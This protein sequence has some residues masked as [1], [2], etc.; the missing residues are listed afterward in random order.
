MDCSIKECRKEL[1]GVSV[2]LRDAET[3]GEA[4]GEGNANYDTYM[5]ENEGGLEHIV[6]LHPNC[7][8]KVFD[9]IFAQEATTIFTMFIGPVGVMREELGIPT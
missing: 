1:L 5:V 3:R 7:F 6:I 2:L 8:R 4:F 9:E